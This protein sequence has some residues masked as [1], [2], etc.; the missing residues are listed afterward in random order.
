MSD[1]EQRIRDALARLKHAGSD[2]ERFSAAGEFTC[3]CGTVAVRAILDDLTALRTAN[4]GLRKDLEAAQAGA[5]GSF[6]SG[7]GGW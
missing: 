6:G 1:A 3:E 7:N 4:E 2:Y 5:Q